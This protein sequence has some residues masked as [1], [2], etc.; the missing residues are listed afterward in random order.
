MKERPLFAA[1]SRIVDPL[2]TASLLLGRGDV[3]GSFWMSGSNDDDCEFRRLV[4]LGRTID[5]WHGAGSGEARGLRRRLDRQTT[6]IGPAND[7]KLSEANVAVVG[8]SRGGSHVF[9]QLTHQGVGTLIPV[10]DQVLDQTN[11]G[12][13]VGARADDVGRTPKNGHRPTGGCGR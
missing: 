5:V 8:V 4:A 7:R 11:L 10:D 6:A 9:Q 2:P 3:V 13:H 1:I 12:R